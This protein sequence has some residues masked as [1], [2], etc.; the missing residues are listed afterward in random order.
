MNF[1][2]GRLSQ[3]VALGIPEI[4]VLLVMLVVIVPVVLS[5]A[6]RILMFFAE[7]C[8]VPEAIGRFAAK[9]AKAF[10]AQRAQNE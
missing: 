2:M 3:M 1:K 8:R 6:L 9:S 5:I 4:L 7:L 10:R